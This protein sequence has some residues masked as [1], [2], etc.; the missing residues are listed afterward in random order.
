MLVLLLSFTERLA[1]VGAP[2]AH[3]VVISAFMGS[4]ALVEDELFPTV[5]AAVRPLA[6]VTLHV[7]AEIR[8]PLKLPSAGLTGEFLQTDVPRFALPLVFHQFVKFHEGHLAE[9]AGELCNWGDLPLGFVGSGLGWVTVVWSGSI[10]VI[11]IRLNVEGNFT[12]TWKTNHW[13]VYLA[14]RGHVED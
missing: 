2:V 6:A 1:A 10:G 3:G 4:A 11:V 7:A 12:T 14:G 5:G 8:G 9:V 13:S